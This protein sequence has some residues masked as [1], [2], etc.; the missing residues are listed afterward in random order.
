MRPYCDHCMSFRQKV[1]LTEFA[2]S[3]GS[4]G[5]SASSGQVREGAEKHEIYVAVAIFF[6]RAGW[7]M[8]PSPPPLRIRY[9][10]DPAAGW[11]GREKEKNE[12]YTSAF[13]DH[14]FYD[15]FLQG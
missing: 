11:E 3:F 2:N 14:L 5:S 10:A 6:H 4:S 1:S 7:G 8:A 15:L 12:I 13:G 9:C